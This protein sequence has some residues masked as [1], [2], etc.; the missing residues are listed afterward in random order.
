MDLLQVMLDAVDDSKMEDG[1]S[2][3]MSVVTLI[4]GHEPTTNS[5]IFVSY[6]LAS[7]DDV[8]QKLITE[9]AEYFSDHPV[10]VCVCVCVPYVCVGGGVHVCGCV[11]VCV[12][13]GI[14]V[15]AYV[16]VCL[17]V[18]GGGWGCRCMCEHLYLHVVWHKF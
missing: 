3:V 4:A 11:W 7:N 16:Y 1:H 15:C 2:V 10:C 8:Q 13:V 5:I 12:G 14:Y 18:C 6:L 9:I 17:T